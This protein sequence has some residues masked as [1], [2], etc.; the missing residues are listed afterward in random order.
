MGHRCGSDIIERLANETLL[1]ILPQKIADLIMS[2][3]TIERI[4]FVGVDLNMD[5]LRG[6]FVRVIYEESARLGP[7]PRPYAIPE[8]GLVI[9]VY[10]ARNQDADY[11]RLVVIKELLHAVDPDFLRTA[12]AQ[13]ATHLADK[14]RLPSEVILAT[15]DEGFS[16]EACMDYIS[17]FRAV[18]AMV[19]EPLRELI[20]QKYSEGKI[21]EAE[22]SVL[23]GVPIRYIVALLSDRWPRLRSLWLRDIPPTIKGAK[24]KKRNQNSN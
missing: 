4:V 9:K 10:Y 14:L 8:N 15:E 22:I 19:P 2:D 7:I 6:H 23:T 3:G 16:I 11:I 21:D 17:D 18:V 20:C 24:P 13:E 12:T 1:P 5:I